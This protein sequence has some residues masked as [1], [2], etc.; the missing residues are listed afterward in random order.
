MGQ[1]YTTGKTLERWAKN[2]KPEIKDIIWISSQ[3]A[4]IYKARQKAFLAFLFP[5]VPVD[6]VVAQKW[7]DDFLKKDDYKYVKYDAYLRAEAVK[8][9]AALNVEKE[10]NRVMQNYN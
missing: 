10:L 1:Q 4:D 2:K 7:M 9:G 8:A 6:N 3:P 5:R